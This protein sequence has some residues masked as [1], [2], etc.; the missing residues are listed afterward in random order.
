MILTKTTM[1]IRSNDIVVLS[2]SDGPAEPLTPA[3]LPRSIR[4]PMG[5]NILP[6][7]GETVRRRTRAHVPQWTQLQL[8]PPDSQGPDS[9]ACV[10]GQPENG[11]S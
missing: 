8:P 6:E 10:Q 3:P 1:I 11:L 5:L 2:F 9:R 4:G 7:R